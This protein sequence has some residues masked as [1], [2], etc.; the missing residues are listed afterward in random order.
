MLER[1]GRKVRYVD[2]E[3]VNW[4]EKTASPTPTG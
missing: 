1:A 2:D 4:S 3:L